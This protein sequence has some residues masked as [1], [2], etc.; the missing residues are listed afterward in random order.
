MGH[1]RRL[2]RSTIFILCSISLIVLAEVLTFLGT[3]RPVTLFLLIAGI[4]GIVA[5]V[6]IVASHEHQQV[7]GRAKLYLLFILGG[8][9][10]FIH[11]KTLQQM[12]EASD[13]GIIETSMLKIRQGLIEYS[14]SHNGKLPPASTWCDDVLESDAELSK[15]DFKFAGLNYKNR[16]CIIAF[17]AN[18]AR[19]N[20]SDIPNEVVLLFEAHGPWNISGEANLLAKQDTYDGYKRI[21]LMD[22]TILRYDLQNSKVEQRDPNTGF[23]VAVSL[24]LLWSP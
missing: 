4:M 7:S 2:A 6:C 13:P 16:P 3:W 17:N 9:A 21:L 14:N 8:I 20:L 12:H 5:F 1:S 18:L 19:L 23:F 24:P 22:G 10:I 15:K 11:V